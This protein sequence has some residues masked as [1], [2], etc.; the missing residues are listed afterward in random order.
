MPSHDYA[1]KSSSLHC[2]A[3]REAP[4]FHSALEQRCPS[5]SPHC[6]QGCLSDAPAALAASAKLGPGMLYDQSVSALCDSSLTSFQMPPL[7][8]LRPQFCKFSV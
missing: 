5:C 4:E 1:S 6:S 7:C 3:R 2:C 8:D